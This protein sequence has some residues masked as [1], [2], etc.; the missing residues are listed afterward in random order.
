MGREGVGATDTEG[1]V[2]DSQGGLRKRQREPA[3]RGQLEAFL[4][5]GR[6]SGVKGGIPNPRGHRPQPRPQDLT[7]RQACRGFLYEQQGAVGIFGI[8]L[9]L[10]GRSPGPE[11]LLIPHIWTALV[12][13]ASSSAISSILPTLRTG[14]GGATQEGAKSQRAGG[15]GLGGVSGLPRQPGVPPV[16]RGEVSRA[17]PMLVEGRVLNRPGAR[18]PGLH[19]LTEPGPS[20]GEAIYTPP[21]AHQPNRP[22]ADP[23]CTVAQKLGTAAAPPSLTLD[24]GTLSSYSRWGNSKMTAPP[25]PTEEGTA[26]NSGLQDGGK[27]NRAIT[28]RRQHLKSVMLQIA[29]T[30]LEQE[31][32]R[33]ESEKQSYLQEHCPPLHIPG[34]MAEVQELCKQLHAKVDVAEEE[35]Y[36]M[37]I[38]VQKSTKELEDMNQKLFD[39]RGKFK[40]PPLRRVRMSADAML[41]ALLGSKHKVCMDLRANLKQVKKED[42]EK[43]RDLRDVGDWRKNIEEKSGMEGRKKMFESES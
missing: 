42:T 20:P 29:A 15:L 30:E 37:E 1:K 43:E 34:S 39:L 28:A 9:G 22:P 32:S 7:P 41:K 12:S 13:K 36:D 19:A 40:R 3:P 2:L 27:R 10:W 4:V 18:P 5:R 11:H 23:L 14:V 38:R 26:L 6:E 25:T 8:R 24:F 35:K 21:L 17:R 16:G 33:R 31:G